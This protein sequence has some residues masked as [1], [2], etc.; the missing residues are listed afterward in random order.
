ME[1]VP[2]NKS[3]ILKL[4]KVNPFLIDTF[5]WYYLSNKSIVNEIYDLFNNNNLNDDYIIYETGI[6]SV[7]DL[8]CE[9]K[10]GYLYYIETYVKS[11]EYDKIFNFSDLWIKHISGEGVKITKIKKVENK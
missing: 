11:T 5:R 2:I 10:K 9:N 3:D 7:I 1:K 4:N 6:S 8:E